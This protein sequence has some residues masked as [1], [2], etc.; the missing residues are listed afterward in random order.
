MLGQ[1]IYSVSTAKF[2]Q[3]SV[4][5]LGLPVTLEWKSALTSL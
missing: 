3:M 5:N 4:T 1:I 2:F